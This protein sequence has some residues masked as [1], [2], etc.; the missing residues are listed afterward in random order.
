MA[1][2][3]DRVCGMEFDSSQTPAQ[4]TSRDKA[5]YF[6]SDECRRTFDELPEEFTG[7]TADQADETPPAP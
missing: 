3:K 5:Y 6:C 4:T 7:K 1:M 2:V